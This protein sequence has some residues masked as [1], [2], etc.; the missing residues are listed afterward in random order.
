MKSVT[1]TLCCLMVSSIVLAQP[2]VQ[3]VPMDPN[4]LTGKLPNGM[5]YYI[6][7][8]E[9]PKDRASF[10]IIQNVG[11]L[12][13]NDAQNGLA[14]FLEHMAFNGTTHFP[15]KGIIDTLEKHGVAFGRNINA[16]TAYNETAYNISNVPMD[17]E[18]LLDTC[19]MVLHDWSN[20]LL[21]TAE[22][23]DAERGVITEEWRTRRTAAFRLQH[24]YLPVLFKDSQYA[25]RDVIGDLDVIQNFKYDTIRQF[26]HD[27]YRTDLQAI[28]IVGDF[29]AQAVRQKVIDLFSPIPAV[30]NPQTRPFFAVPE[31][32]EPRFCLATDKEASANTI[33]LYIKHRI[34]EDNRNTTQ[35]LR[36]R[37]ISS[38]FNSMT[39]ARINELLQKGQPPFISGAI[40]HGG[41]IRGYDVFVLQA[42]ANPNE[43]AQALKAITSEAERVRRHGFTPGELQRA[44]T[45]MQTSWDIQFKQRDKINH[46]RYARQMQEHFLA[47]EPLPSIEYRYRYVTEALPTITLEEV[48]SRAQQWMTDQNR[49][50]VISGEDDPNTTHL[51]RDEAFGIIEKVKTEEI[52]PYEDNLAGDSL[53]QGTLAAG[54]IVS[55]TPLP[56]FDAVQWTLSNNA[57]VIFRHADFEKDSVALRAFSL[58][59]SSLID[60]NSIPEAMMIDSLVGAYGVGEF[61]NVSLRKFMAGKK[62]S[63]GVSLGEVTEGFS[64][65]CTPKDFETM[66]QLL[67]LKFSQPRFDAQ[68]HNALMTRYHNHVAT[69]A[70]NP[71]KIMQDHLTHLLSNNN[72]RARVLDES[73]LNEIDLAEIERIYRDRYS[74]AEDFCFIIVG[75]LEAET[76]KPLV[77]TYIGSLKSTDRTETFIDRK[78]NPPSGKTVKKIEVPLTVPKA[79]VVLNINSP[80]DYTAYNRVCLSVINGILDIRFVETVREEEGGT[81]GVSCSL[82]L[83]KN[84]ENKA[85]ATFRFDCDPNKADHLK[86]IIYQELESISTEGPS[87]EN[88]A[89]TVSNLL[90]DRQEARQHNS[91]WLS[92]IYTYVYSGIN[93]DASAN[94]SDILNRLTAEDIKQ[95]AT[96]AFSGDVVDV[97]FI[98]EEK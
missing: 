67:Y 85:E 23:I 14:H 71:Q 80:M 19:L 60:T 41:L 33:S 29:D 82:S 65:S 36:D 11:A 28:A 34:D 21:L 42:R 96:A 35:T 49:V 59:G 17:H 1:F 90:K 6:R 10:Y 95:V 88:L 66:L 52:E 58:G 92:S 79:T 22:E 26:Y 98:P 18:G 5:T 63:C 97:T 12:L 40:Q 50:L 89:K 8:N 94:F 2:G 15:G 38:L 64:G 44:K 86:A 84:P 93:P 30:E 54:K 77:E 20:D 37:T 69:L 16:Y 87:Q 62:A 39:S 27:W 9:E 57:K 78:V 7:H 24:Q 32:Q 47:D 68:A 45:N 3:P 74:D 81:Y 56:E 53:I 91:Y 73:L 70:N 61:D 46:D 76:V 83:Q 72:P 31:H 13:E 55:E 51:T 43:E 48:S 75:N 4:I 25:V